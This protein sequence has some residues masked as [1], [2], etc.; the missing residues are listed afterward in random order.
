VSAHG[1]LHVLAVAGL[2]ALCATVGPAGLQAG[3]PTVP[4]GDAREVIAR[5]LEAYGGRA[6][7]ERVVSYRMEGEFTSARDDRSGPTARVLVRPNKLKVAIHYPEETEL[8]LLDGARGWRTEEGEWVEAEGPMYDA[9]VL[10]AMRANVPWILAEGAAHAKLVEPRRHGGTDLIG[11]EIPLR[12]GLAFRAY[13]HPRTYR[14][15][16][17]RGLLAHYGMETYFETEYSDFRRVGGV[18]FAFRE[19][20]FA[21]GVHTGWTRIRR[22]VLNPKLSPDEFAPPRSKKT[23]TRDVG[24]LPRPGRDARCT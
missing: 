10:Q 11:V 13:V 16:V 12:E 6:A 21:S 2:L 14:V 22:V 24:L 8:R 15:E 9:M 17:S 19:K 3:G 18:L 4:S 20:N 5:V 1:T 7:L 23:G